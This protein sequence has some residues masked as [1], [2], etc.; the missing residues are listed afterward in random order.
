MKN[1]TLADPFISVSLKADVYVFES[2]TPRGVCL[3]LPR[4]K[5]AADADHELLGIICMGEQTDTKNANACFWDNQKDKKSTPI[6]NSGLFPLNTYFA[7]GQE[8]DGGEGG[9]CTACHAGETSYV[10]HPDDPAFNNLTD[11]GSGGWYKPMVA[12]SWPQNP[13]PD[14][15]FPAVP[16]GEK[17]CSTCHNLPKID[18]SL[19]PYCDSVLALALEKTM[20]PAGQ[21]AKLGGP[22][23]VGYRYQTHNMYLAQ[24]CA[25]AK[26]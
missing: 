22:F 1:G 12:A 20:P 7:A 15:A 2:A 3:A 4:H 25:D 10:V 19:T 8:L 13:G 24:V 14:A 9:T 18:K 16:A 5:D 11:I 21:R 23:P 6:P 17:K 26:K